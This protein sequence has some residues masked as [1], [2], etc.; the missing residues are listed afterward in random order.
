MGILSGAFAAASALGIPFALYL[1]AIGS[2]QIPFLVIGVLAIFVTLFIFF[3]F[4]TMTDHLSLVSK[5]RNLVKVIA[6]IINDKNQVAA[7]LAGFVLVL[8]HFLIIPFISPYLIKNVGLTQL[9]ISYQF[10]FGGVVSVFTSPFVG[11]MVDKYGFFRIFLIMS[12][13]YTHLTLPT[14]CSV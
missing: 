10:F 11:R 14:I 12:V 7:L 6:D 8:G 1:A 3:L 4:P 2:W 13:S 5:D 9:E